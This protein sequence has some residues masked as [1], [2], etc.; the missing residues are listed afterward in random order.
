MTGVETEVYT[1]GRAVELTGITYRQL[2]Y[3]TSSGWLLPEGASGSGHSRLWTIDELNVMSR[4]V[5]LVEVGLTPVVAV[6]VARGGRPAEHGNP[7]FALTTR[8]VVSTVEISLRPW[9]LV[10]P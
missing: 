9:E 5:R 1:S 2:D 10:S 3:W 6:V 8:D 4:M 7:S